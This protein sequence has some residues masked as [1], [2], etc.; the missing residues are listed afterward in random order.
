MKAG[1][2][3]LLCDTVAMLMDCGTC[4]SLTALWFISRGGVLL[5]AANSIDLEP[6]FC[7]QLFNGD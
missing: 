2:C 3:A 1:G 6:T 7:K 4:E 5:E